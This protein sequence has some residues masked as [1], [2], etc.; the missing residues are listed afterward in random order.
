MQ[1][2]KQ[3]PEEVLKILKQN[4]VEYLELNYYA[5]PQ[6]FSS[7]TGP[8]GGMGGQVMSTFTIEAWVC[9][10]SGPTV[11]TCA[12]MYSFEDEKFWPLKHIK[13]WEKIE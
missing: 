13:N 1:Y 5:W 4:K 11:F 3:A 9:D 2:Q 10:A 6:M 7:T 8:C 12:G